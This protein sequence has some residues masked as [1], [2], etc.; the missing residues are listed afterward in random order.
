VQP[1]RKK[2]VELRKQLV[3]VKRGYIDKKYLKR[4]DKNPPPPPPPPLPL[5]PKEVVLCA[6]KGLTFGPFH[7]FYYPALGLIPFCIGISKHGR[8]SRATLFLYRTPLK[9]TLEKTSKGF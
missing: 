9:N 4:K 5:P 3:V 6:R 2:K 1:A 8:A 7:V